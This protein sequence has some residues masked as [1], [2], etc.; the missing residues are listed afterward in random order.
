MKQFGRGVFWKWCK[1]LQY[2]YQVQYVPGTCTCIRYIGNVFSQ[3]TSTV[4]P[5]TVAETRTIFNFQSMELLQYEHLY[6]TS[7][8]YTNAS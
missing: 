8:L 1:L 3:G 7:L 2:K 6:G 5:S 4:R